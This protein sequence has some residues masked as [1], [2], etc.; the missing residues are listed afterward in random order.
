[1]DLYQELDLPRDCSFD[2][3][4]Q[5]YRILA[6]I[7]HPDKGGD[8]EKFKKIK[9]AYEVLS[10]PDRRSEYDK[11]GN[12]QNAPDIKNQARQNLSQ[13]FFGLLPNFDP[14]SGDIIEIIKH[15]IT[16]AIESIS[17]N[18]T[19]SNTYITKL[20]LVKSKI[21][22]KDTDID[23]DN[24]FYSFIDSQ[25]EVRRNDL[26]NMNKRV[27]IAKEMLKILDDYSYGYI[28]LPVSGGGF[29]HDGGG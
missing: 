25:L 3:I 8:E 7:Y 15:E 26:N 17:N 24:L 5:Q 12:T 22:K 28:E 9:F 6:Q 21:R 13:I 10:D 27:E 16:G 2:N 29:K 14:T 20:E 11:S 19:E 1:M 18:K 23:P 4:K